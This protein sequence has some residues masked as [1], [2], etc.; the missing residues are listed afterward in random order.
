MKIIKELHDDDL[1]QSVIEMNPFHLAQVVIFDSF[2]V[3]CCYM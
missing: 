1:L 2:L 3:M